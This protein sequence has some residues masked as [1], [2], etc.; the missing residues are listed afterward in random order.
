MVRKS[1]GGTGEV[2]HRKWTPSRDQTPA[3][4]KGS[5]CHGTILGSGG[6]EGNP[7][8]KS[9]FWLA[10]NSIVISLVTHLKEM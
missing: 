9:H 4:M 6:P 1:F 3:A 2:G 7:E 5:S 10:R 8:G